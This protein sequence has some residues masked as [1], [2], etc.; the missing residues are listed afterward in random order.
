MLDP[1]VV[2]DG[3]RVQKP[4]VKGKV[5][6]PF[7]EVLSLGESVGGY[8]DNARELTC[9]R[10]CRNRARPNP[11]SARSTTSRSFGRPSRSFSR[12]PLPLRFGSVEGFPWLSPAKDSDSSPVKEDVSQR[13]W[14]CPLWRSVQSR[15]HEENFPFSHFPG[16]CSRCSPIAQEVIHLPDP[17]LGIHLS[18]STRAMT[19][20][21]LWDYMRFQTRA[22]R[23]FLWIR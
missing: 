10:A 15:G 4:R 16:D 5:S 17:V 19:E 7:H 13:R 22:A 18:G 2:G 8:S 6:G 14:C 21:P 1:L 23:V 11:Q 3:T 20:T 12:K 9:S